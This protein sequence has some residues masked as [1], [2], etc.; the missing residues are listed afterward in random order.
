VNIKMSLGEPLR[1]SSA[2]LVRRSLL[3]SGYPL[4]QPLHRF[5]V[6]CLVPL[7]SLSQQT[8]Y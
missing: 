4:H 8:P 3:A 7:L 2:P 5:A 1:R 6:S